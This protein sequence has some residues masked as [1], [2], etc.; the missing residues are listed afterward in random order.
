MS[1]RSPDDFEPSASPELASEDAVN[2]GGAPASPDHGAFVAERV[3]RTSYDLG[4]ERQGVTEMPKAAVSMDLAA[5]HL[6]A[7]ADKGGGLAPLLNLDSRTGRILYSAQRGPQQRLLRSSHEAAGGTRDMAALLDVPVYLITPP[8]A[9]TVGARSVRIRLAAYFSRWLCMEGYENPAFRSA[10]QAAAGEDRLLVCLFRMAMACV[11]LESWPRW[12]NAAVQSTHVSLGRTLLS[13]VQT[14]VFLLN[15][16]ETIAAAAHA[17]AKQPS[18]Q[19]L[20]DRKTLGDLVDGLCYLL[21]TSAANASAANASVAETAMFASEHEHVRLVNAIGFLLFVLV[22]PDSVLA[23]DAL[24]LLCANRYLAALLGTIV[25]LAEENDNGVKAFFP[26]L[27][28]ESVAG[29]QPGDFTVAWPNGI[30]FALHAT[31][32]FR[33]VLDAKLGDDQRL[34]ERLGARARFVARA[35]PLAAPSEF[36]HVPATNGGGTGT[37]GG[38]SERKRAR[39]ELPASPLRTS[40]SAAASGGATTATTAK[41]KSA[42]LLRPEP[43][44]PEAPPSV[45]E[46]QTVNMTLANYVAEDSAT[47]I[48]SR[49]LIALQWLDGYPDAEGPPEP[50]AERT[51]LFAQ[52]PLL[53]EQAEALLAVRDLDED[54]PEDSARSR[55]EAQRRAASIVSKHT[56]NDDNPLYRMCNP[57]VTAIS[58]ASAARSALI[59]QLM[60]YMTHKPRIIN[61]QSCARSAMQGFLRS[62]TMPLASLMPAGAAAAALEHA[63]SSSPPVPSEPREPQSELATFVRRERAS[64][65]VQ[66]RPTSG[67][68]FAHVAIATSIQRSKDANAGSK[69]LTS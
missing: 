36:K 17:H 8:P 40:S 15:R 2:G 46:P 9:W 65:A 43:R 25:R 44:W 11:S 23:D 38:D 63:P 47:C 51:Q 67:V 19:G 52:G 69:L 29:S 35:W 48:A 30:L 12:S 18:V 62:I 16:D 21:Y 31:K 5:L 66:S 37:G 22:S 60:C 61:A 49:A 57:E 6:I 55:A 7:A 41:R 68:Q 1:S 42:T 50:K 64:A 56:L 26:A 45:P 3:I 10:L 33:A 24:A 13:A 14:L 34:V 27:P 39:V 20:K 53:S 58:A 59:G 54:E 4:H 28:N 32:A